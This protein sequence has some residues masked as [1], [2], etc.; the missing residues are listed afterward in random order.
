MKILNIKYYIRNTYDEY[1]YKHSF[2][3]SH[4]LFFAQRLSLLLD[5]NISLV[6]SLQMMKNIDKSKYRKKLYRVVIIDC[7]RGVSLSNSLLS[8]QIIL[9]PFLITLIKNGESSGTLATSLLQAY[10]NLY[11]RNDL[12]NKLISTLLYPIF[13]FCATIIMSLFL[14]LYIFPKILP[15]LASLNIKLPLITRIVRSIYELSNNYGIYIASILFI[16][17]FTI[18]FLIKNNKR[19]RY[20]KD[21]I[22]LSFPILG[23]Y[24]K[25]NTLYSVCNISGMLLSSGKTLPDIHKFSIDSINN[26]IIKKSFID[27]YKQSMAGI[28]FSTSMRSSSF[29][30][31]QSMVDM[32]E[33]GEK[34][35]NLIKMF[36]HI[37]NIFEQDI[38]TILKRFSSL[39]EPTLMIF[40]GLVVGSIALS[41]IL[42][43]YEITNHLTK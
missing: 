27:I 18:Y 26:L 14:V 29:T 9:N 33:L 16:I 7:D 28:S 41:I 15:L 2:S 1:R 10:E 22:L 42:P 19:I 40:M 30:F 36:K 4:Q 13:I 20:F 35:G 12:R 8:S 34:T 43:V 31:P 5:S 3:L 24:I 6:D 32:C 25:I 21:K 17:L 23:N 38:D 37:S 11:K 39:I